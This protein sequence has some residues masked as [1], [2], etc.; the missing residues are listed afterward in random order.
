V[1][2]PVSLSVQIPVGLTRNMLTVPFP[3]PFLDMS[4]MKMWIIAQVRAIENINLLVYNN[5]IWCSP[6]SC[7]KTTV[8]ANKTTSSI[9]F[10]W[11]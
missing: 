8:D 6:V 11:N 10:K 2:L 1:I 4:Q 7:G 5:P 9:R 3:A